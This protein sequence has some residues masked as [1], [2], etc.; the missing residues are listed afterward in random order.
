MRVR[1]LRTLQT[2]RSGVEPSGSCS[3]CP[4]AWLPAAACPQL[5]KKHRRWTHLTIYL[6]SIQNCPASCGGLALS[7]AAVT[8]SRPGPGT[9][10]RFC[11]PGR[12]CEE[13]QETE[14]EA[15]LPLVSP[16]HRMLFPLQAP[17]STKN[18]QGRQHTGLCG[19]ADTAFPPGSQSACPW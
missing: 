8:Y 3:P 14:V 7:G 16:S 18:P 19:T 2:V 4:R 1:S 11:G 10:A 9:A 15:C 6:Q 5:T 12:L 13:Q 17:L